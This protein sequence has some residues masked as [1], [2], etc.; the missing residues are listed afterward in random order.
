MIYKNIT[1]I[2]YF[3]E[4]FKKY[5]SAITYSVD[6]HKEA[7]QTEF[8]SNPTYVGSFKNCVVHS[9]PFLITED[10]HLITNHVWPLLDKVRNKPHKSHKL[11]KAWGENVNIDLPSV[12]KV[13]NE[14]ETYVW[15]PIDEASAENPWHIWI[16]VISKFRLM[17]GTYNKPL[18]NFVFILSN[19][20]KYFNRVIE[21]IF[22]NIKYHVMPKQSVWRFK[23]L[24][25]PTMSNHKDGILVPDMVT[26]IRKN[27]VTNTSTNNRKIFISR[28]D[29]LL[30]KLT[31]AE[32]LFMFLKGWEII[33]L[34]KLSIKEQIKVFAEA[35]HVMSTHGAGLTNLLW[36]QPDTRV[37]E[38]GILEQIAK[39]VYP[40][41]SYC[42]QLKHKLILGELIKLNFEKKP[43]NI[44]RLRNDGNIKINVKELLE[45]IEQ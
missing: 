37:Y 8:I 42:L 45:E 29:A 30:R 7:P 31:N 38:I 13:F 35:S 43:A 18:K 40:V 28:E 14:E 22:P 27:V 17:L 20:S 3:E 26:W 4:R 2:K 39:K 9:L 12:T 33:T 1:S 15:L 44:K 23:E 24:I 34:S 32:E 5:D 41:L 21:E 11:W 10:H 36:C 6:Y 25:V 19:E 16:D